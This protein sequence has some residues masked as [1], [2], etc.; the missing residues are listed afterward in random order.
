VINYVTIFLM[1]YRFKLSQHKPL[2]HIEGVNSALRLFFTLAVDGGKWSVS[3]RSEFIQ[4]KTS[5][6]ALNGGLDEFQ[7]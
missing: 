6:Y 7:R 1:K 5:R 2:S 4:G 3:G